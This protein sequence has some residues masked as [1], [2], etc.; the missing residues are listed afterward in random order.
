MGALGPTVTLVFAGDSDRLSRTLAKVGAETE[1]FGGKVQRMADQSG[2]ALKWMGITAGASLGLVA[3]GLA[4]VPTLFAGMGIAA[5]MHTK[6]VMDAFTSLKTHVVAQVQD[7]AKPFIPVLTGLAQEAQKT[8][9]AIGPS[10]RKMFADVAPMVGEVVG[11][12]L[13]FVQGAMP[14]LQKALTGARPVIDALSKGIVSL[15]P[16]FGQMFANFAKNGQAAGSAL[17]MVF[18]ILAKLLPFIGDLASIIVRLSPI[19]L[20][21]ASGFWLAA[22]AMKAVEIVLALFNIELAATPVG[23]IIIAIGLLVAGLIYLMTHTKQVKEVWNAVW[24]FV[25]RIAAEVA[26]WVVDKWNGVI[27]WFQSLPGAIGRIFSAVGHAIAAPFEAAFNGI[28]SLWNNTVGRINFTIPSWIP[29]IG[30]NHFGMPKF[31]QGGVVPGTPGQEVMAILQA[32]ETV[33][34]AGRSTG[35]GQMVISFAGN[36]DSAFASAF[37]KMVR[38][39]QIQIATG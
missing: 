24:S 17:K 6:E 25:K 10:L 34:P 39:G 3:G 12:I 31:H 1:G 35:S 21:L 26:D 37:M 38:T 9:D 13:K 14:G 27:H 22:K 29:G 20:P 19:L 30:G 15:G 4:L 7:M 36:T 2:M 28:K 33:T 5:V 16:A 23:W 8:F 32:G 11:A 18:D